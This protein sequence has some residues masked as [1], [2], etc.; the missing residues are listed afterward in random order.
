MKKITYLILLATIMLVTAGTAKN[1]NAEDAKISVPVSFSYSSAYW[2]RGVV[3]P[4]NGYLWPGA[5][6]TYGALSLTA[7]AGI[8]ENWIGAENTADENTA[9]AL[10]ELDLGA[11]YT[12]DSK[13]VT[14]GLGVMYVGYPYY[15]ASDKDATEASFIE[16]NVTLTVKTFLSPYVAFYYDYYLNESDAETPTAE[17]YYV[18]AG[19]SHNLISTEDGFAFSLGGYVGYYNNA[20]FELSGWSDA[21]LTA[22]TSKSYKNMS[23]TSS[24]N[25]GRTLSKDFKVANGGKKNNFWASF[26]ATV[27]L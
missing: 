22:G 4:G 14:I 10:T 25:Y 11:A 19:V 21:V 3:L 15:D 16:S 27:T 2:W 8:S 20:Y 12:I 17:D 23:F 1:V 24:F 9:K 13:M 5:G 26:G 7:A 6:L 18:K